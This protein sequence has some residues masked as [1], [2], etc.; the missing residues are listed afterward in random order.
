MAFLDKTIP[1]EIA[2]AEKSLAKFQECQS[3]VQMDVKMKNGECVRMSRY[4]AKLAREQ[5]REHRHNLRRMIQ[6]AA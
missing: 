2:K 6:V 3:V 1:S 5:W 4:D